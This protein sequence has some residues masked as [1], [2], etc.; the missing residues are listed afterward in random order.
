MASPTKEWIAVVAHHVLGR[1]NVR[2]SLPIM[3]FLFFYCFS[4]F[5]VF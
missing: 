1:P 5:F 3:N 2:F 4:S